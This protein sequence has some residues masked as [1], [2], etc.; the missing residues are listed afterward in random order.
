MSRILIAVTHLLGAGH[1]TR[2]AALARAF[3][4]AGH[5][6]TLVSGGMPA[7]LAGLDGIRLV[8]LPPVRIA[9]TAF[10]ALLDP[11]G[12]PVAAERL[13]ARRDALV[14]A[15]AEAA[16]EAVITELWP[17]GRR[18]LAPEFEALAAAARA[19]SPRPRPLLLASIRDILATPSRPERIAATHAR[20]ADYDAV[21]VH[22]DPALLPLDASWPL[23]PAVAGRLR[24]TGYVDE[25][26]AAPVPEGPRAGI[27]VSGGSSAA[28]LPLQEAAVAAASLTPF[29]S[30]RILVG[31]AVP[32]PA[33]AAL[34]AAAPANAVV[35]RA[36]PDF[37]ALLGGC[38][39]SVSQAGYN[40]VLDLLHGGCPAVLVPF[41]AGH[42]TEQR[43]R[44]DTLAA[45]GLAR[46]LPEDALT[47]ESL[48]QAVL[49]PPPPG[50]PHAIARDGA[51]RSVAIVEG[52]LAENRCSR[53]SQSSGEVRISPLSA[54]GE[55]LSSPSSG[56]KAARSAR[57]RGWFRRSLIRRYPLTLAPA[58]PAL[59][60]PPT[61]G[62]EPSPRPRSEGEPVQAGP[63]GGGR[64]AIHPLSDFRL[65]IDALTRA[66]DEGRTV[67][68]WWRDDDATAHTP[69]LDRLLALASRSGWPLALAAVPARAEPSLAG[70]LAY[71][72][73]IDLLVHGLA[74]ADHA[75]PGSKTA[76]LGPHR[77]PTALRADAADALALATARL[78]PRLLPVLVPPWNR[79]APDL[80][81]A[82][83]AL[84]YRGVSAAAPL[85]PVPGLIQAHAAVDPVAWRA[86]GGLA[87][88]AW[89]I[90]KAAR[91]VAAGGPVGL[92]THH[93]VQDEA[94]WTFCARLLDRLAAQA[95]SGRGPRIS[96]AAA[97]F[98]HPASPVSQPSPIF[99]GDPGTPPPR[100]DST[101]P[102]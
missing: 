56:T 52:L 12:A 11:D 51:R 22:G 70:R 99:R 41:E 68:L 25:G 87:D 89:I 16:P 59:A 96:R 66:A 101:A 84:G 75:P 35:E 69:A 26:A 57:V 47:A 14:Q 50:A 37:R 46:V 73:G 61:R 98:A 23:D 79:I 43:L 9:G 100:E 20:L 85:P 15:F 53:V 102:G 82:L 54:G 36:R 92:L 74:H 45:H 64:P 63:S 3:A 88:P 29:L 58:A 77:S 78:G 81:A 72:A 18:V 95:A 49:A 31:R 94:T 17:F 40:T 34:R 83:P 30:W 21:L 5:A 1:L 38:A 91:A 33:F 80:V 10:T 19:T 7:A 24:Y 60:P 42:E 86:G 93:L 2:A 65:L 8:Q 39:L 4:A 62:A 97:L 13:A 6:V 27:V 48:A 76:E 71:E 44:A 67:D 32:E 55:R 28:G 90:D